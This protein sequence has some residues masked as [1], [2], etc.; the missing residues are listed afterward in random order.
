MIKLSKIDQIYYMKMYNVMLLVMLFHIMLTRQLLNLNF[1]SLMHVNGIVRPI[2]DT[3]IIQLRLFSFT[4]YI[5]MCRV[6]YYYAHLY[7][8][9]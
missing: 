1:N 9:D 2:Y 8:H 4:N 7:L 3:S 5:L 6:Y